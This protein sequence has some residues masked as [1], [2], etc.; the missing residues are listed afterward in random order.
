MSGSSAEFHSSVLHELSEEAV[1]GTVVYRN[2]A[3]SGSSH[4][5]G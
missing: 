2:K 5:Q 1:L 4:I 3:K